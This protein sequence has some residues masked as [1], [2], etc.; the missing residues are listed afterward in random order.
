MEG[1]NQIKISL[2]MAIILIFVLMTAIISVLIFVV[3]Q[4]NTNTTDKSLP[5]AQNYNEVEIENINQEKDTEI[6]KLPIDETDIQYKDYSIEYYLDNYDKGFLTTTEE[7]TTKYEIFDNYSDYIDCYNSIDSWAT[8]MIEKYSE[9]TN[10]RI[11]TAVAEHPKSY[12]NPEVIKENSIKQYRESIE[13]R[14]GKI[15]E[16]FKKENYSKDF[17]DNNTLILIEHSVYGQVLHEME[18]NNVER[19][20][21][22]LNIKFST[23]VAGVVGG[24]QCRIFFIVIPKQYMKTINDIK[25]I[26]GSTNTSIPGVAYKPIIYL[27]PT[28]KTNVS[29]KLLKSNNITCSYPKYINGWNVTAE[30]NG[31]LID[32]TTGRSLYSLYYESENVVNFK[33]ENDG[34][35]VK[36]NEVATFLEEKLAILG[37]TEREAEEFIIYW[38]PKLEANKYNYI[39]FATLDEINENMPLEINPNPDIIIRVLMT[40]KGLENPIDIQEQQLETPNRTG[41][42]AVEWGGTEI[43]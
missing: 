6:S 1:R 7:E 29:L 2:K 31:N 12:S 24:G 39:R 27:Y 15:K 30:T 11:D 38:L 37:L 22:T 43:K 10:N 36:G 14:V 33:V 18:I 40:F 25:V 8:D 19:K 28:E 41:F 35:I 3:Y 42:V 26:V 23:E 13:D 32:N 4:K 5:N 21:N 34:F 20:N 9:D 17:F 16:G